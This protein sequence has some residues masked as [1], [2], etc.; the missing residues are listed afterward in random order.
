MSEMIRREENSNDLI[1]GVVLEDCTGC[2]Y[3]VSFKKCYGG[4]LKSTQRI[5]DSQ[6]I[7][8][9]NVHSQSSGMTPPC[10]A[11]SNSTNMIKL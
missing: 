2:Q 3:M 5:K 10:I 8:C 11:I 4:N 6:L 7:S 1:R 9:V